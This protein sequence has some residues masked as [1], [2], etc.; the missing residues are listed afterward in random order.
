LPGKRQNDCVFGSGPDVKELSSLFAQAY[1]HRI[2]EHQLCATISNSLANLFTRERLQLTRI[3]ADEQDRF[4]VTNVAM[5]CEWSA[6][7][8]EERFETEEIRGGEVFSSDQLR[9]K[10]VQHE[11]GFVR[12]SRAADDANRVSPV[13]IGDRVQALGDVTNSFIPGCGRNL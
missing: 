2:Y 6:E 13:C 5:R 4:S 8:F 12:K 7:I 11:Q 10:P 3:A 1:R 9:R